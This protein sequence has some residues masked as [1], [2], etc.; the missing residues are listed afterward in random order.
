MSEQQNFSNLPPVYDRVTSATET[1]EELQHRLFLEKA[2]FFANTL[3]VFLV[4]V[5]LTA[6]LFFNEDA[7]LK[8]SAQVMLQALAAGFIGYLAKR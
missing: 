7:E 8:K 1:P 5:L 3:G 2:Q 4:F 6:I